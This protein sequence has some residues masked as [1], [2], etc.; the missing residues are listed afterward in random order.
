MGKKHVDI[1]LKRLY[2]NEALK[3]CKK[4]MGINRRKRNTPKIYVRVRLEQED[5]IKKIVEGSYYS[6]NNRIVIYGLNCNKLEDVVST[7]IHEYTHYL[8]SMKKYWEYF[9]T[10]YYSQ[11]P[12]ERQAKRNEDKYTREC[13][14]YI[15]RLIN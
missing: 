11:H 10:H 13:Y 3:W 15:R 1:E 8:Q 7:V 2:A 5:K 6:E 12:Y 4:N 14:N 9:Q